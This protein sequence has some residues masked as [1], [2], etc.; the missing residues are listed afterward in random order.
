MLHYVKI[1][2]SLTNSRFTY[3]TFLQPDGKNTKD[4][5]NHLLDYTSVYILTI[6]VSNYLKR[7]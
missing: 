1:R 2:C 7:I 5:L 6:T 4:E 3:K